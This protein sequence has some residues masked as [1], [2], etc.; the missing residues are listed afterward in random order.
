MYYY[1]N[2]NTHENFDGRA[3]TE[4]GNAWNTYQC[5]QLPTVREEE[6]VEKVNEAEDEI[7]EYNEQHSDKCC[8]C[9]VKLKIGGETRS[10]PHAV[11]RKL[12]EIST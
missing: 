1:C 4:E 3:L 7:W 12:H 9:Q 2:N 11:V 10:K 5:P 8:R 6:R